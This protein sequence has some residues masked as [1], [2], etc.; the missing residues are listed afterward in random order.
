MTTLNQ[1]GAR[2]GRAHGATSATDVTGFGLLGH[3]RNIVRGS[4]VGARIELAELPVL[5]DALAHLRDRVCPAGS[6]ANR[7]F[8]E[9][10]VRWADGA[11]FAAEEGDGDRELLA[12][13]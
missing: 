6:R 5:P 7:A 9:P 10:L 2:I 11:P 1:G 12:S 13:L 3:L 4:G 8:V